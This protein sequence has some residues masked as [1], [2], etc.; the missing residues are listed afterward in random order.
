MPSPAQSH[1]HTP[2]TLLLDA[3]R[4]LMIAAEISIVVSTREAK[5][6]VTKAD[7]WMCKVLTSEVIALLVYVIR[8]AL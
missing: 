6:A 5:V 7:L 8:R 1:V 4:Y 3:T 2:K